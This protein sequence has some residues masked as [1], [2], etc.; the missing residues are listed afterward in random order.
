[1]IAHRLLERLDGV[2]KTA[3]DAWVARCP[4]H[5]DR[6]PSLAVRDVGDRVLIHCHAGCGAHAVVEALGLDMAD[7]FERAADNHQGKTQRPTFNARGVLALVAADATVVYVAGAHLARGEALSD[8]DQAVLLA[9][10][11]RIRNAAWLAGCI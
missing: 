2:R 3:R 11:G 8:S 4:A 1:M 9:A 7:L 5:E 10:V 6:S